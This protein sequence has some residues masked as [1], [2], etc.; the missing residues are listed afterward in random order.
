MQVLFLAN[1]SET[2]SYV[3]GPVSTGLEP[4]TCLTQC[5]QMVV[6][7]NKPPKKGQ[8]RDIFMTKLSHVWSGNAFKKLSLCY[9]NVSAKNVF[10]LSVMFRNFLVRKS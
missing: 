9:Q 3:I 4:L 10:N 7:N 8:V 2:L 1:T 5:L 6:N